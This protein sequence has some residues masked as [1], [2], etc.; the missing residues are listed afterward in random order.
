MFE[1]KGAVPCSTFS[2]QTS[3]WLVL[4]TKLDPGA[5]LLPLDLSYM[6]TVQLFTSIELFTPIAYY[7]LACTTIL[8][9]NSY[10]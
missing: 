6:V 4:P 3:W 8:T 5:I 9:T 2:Y 7:I 1:S 10:G